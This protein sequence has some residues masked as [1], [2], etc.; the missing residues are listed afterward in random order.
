[1]VWLVVGLPL[2][3]V[4]AS[5]G[6]L[7]QA[8]HGG[9]DDAVIDPVQHTAQMQVPERAAEQR[10]AELNLSAT[11]SATP[12]GIEVVPVSGRF[13]RSKPL[14]L[15]FAHPADDDHDIHQLLAPSTQGWAGAAVS[16]E[17]NDWVIRLE[18]EDGSWRLRGRLPRGQQAVL[19][20]AN[21]P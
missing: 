1:M 7:S 15:T 5:F 2:G 9:P 13:D 18:T 19:L 16:T 8:L 14:R 11:L 17:S 20:R 10:A 21:A 6:L 3:A 12:Q 4:L